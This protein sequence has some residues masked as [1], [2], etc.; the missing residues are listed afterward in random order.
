MK[1]EVIAPTKNEYVVA[2]NV[3]GACTVA[4]IKPA[5]ANKK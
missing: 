2:A 4:A 5:N 3:A 1:K